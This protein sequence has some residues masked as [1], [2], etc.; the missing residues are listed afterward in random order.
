MRTRDGFGMPAAGTKT[1]KEVLEKKEAGWVE[2]TV[3]SRLC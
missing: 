1:K 3:L 2:N